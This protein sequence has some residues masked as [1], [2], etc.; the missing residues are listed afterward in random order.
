MSKSKFCGYC[1]EQHSGQ[2][3]EA[4]KAGKRVK[5]QLDRINRILRKHG[6]KEMA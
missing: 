2:C 1:G 3:A 4:K 5:A 6:V